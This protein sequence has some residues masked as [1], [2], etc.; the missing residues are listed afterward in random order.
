MSPS[1]SHHLDHTAV[2]VVDRQRS[3]ADKLPMR[4]TVPSRI[5]SRPACPP[6]ILFRQVLLVFYV[7]HVVD[8][9]THVLNCLCVADWLIARD[10]SKDYSTCIISLHLVVV[11]VNKKTYVFV[12]C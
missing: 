2:L 12:K 7:E 10:T 6:E 9:R 4:E 11:I 8:A 3:V 1:S 5:R